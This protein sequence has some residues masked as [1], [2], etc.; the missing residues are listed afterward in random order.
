MLAIHELGETIIGDLTQFQI[1]KNEKEKMEHDAVHQ[2]L[3]ELISGEKIES[4]F[5]KFDSQLTKE[6]IFAY[7]CDKL[8]CDL[9]A[10][11]YDQENCV[12]L[13]NQ[14]GNSSIHDKRVIELMETGISWSEMWINF[15]QKAYNYDENFMSVSQYALKNK[16]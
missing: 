3:G 4:L 11:L 2:I 13:A 15:G 16:I 5:L 8:E 7:Q 1:C 10:K 6:A 14:T 9:Q 12:D